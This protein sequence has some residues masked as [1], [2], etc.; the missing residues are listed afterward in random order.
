MGVECGKQNH[1]SEWWKWGLVL[2]RGAFMHCPVKKTIPWLLA[3][4]VAC[5]GQAGILTGP[6]LQDAGSDHMTVMWESDMEGTGW[7]EYV[8]VATSTTG[9]LHL[10]GS[11]HA[12]HSKSRWY[13]GELTG[14]KVDTEYRYRIGMRNVEDAGG[15]FRTFHTNDQA[16]TFIMYAD[17]QS[18]ARG[19][20]L[21]ASHFL[22]YNPRLIICAG[23]LVV[24]DHEDDTPEY[25]RRVFFDPLD[26]VIRHVPLFVS[27]G[28]HD[29]RRSDE[30]F[31]QYFASP[32]NGLNY[33]FSCGIAQF[34]CM[35]SSG[36]RNRGA[37]EREIFEVIQ[38]AFAGPSPGWRFAFQHHPM[39][40]IAHHGGKWGRYTILPELHRHNVDMVMAGHAH[41]YERFLPIVAGA[42]DN[43]RPIQHLVVGPGGGE[44]RGA[45]THELLA[46]SHGY[47]YNFIV[48]TVDGE[49]LDVMAWDARHSNVIDQFSMTQAG[50]VYDD[51]YMAMAVSRRHERG[52]VEAFAGGTA[53]TN[54]PFGKAYEFSPWGSMLGVRPAKP[55]NDAEGTIEFWVYRAFGADWINIASDE[56]ELSR[57]HLFRVKIGE[58]VVD[59]ITN[60]SYGVAYETCVGGVTNRIVAPLPTQG[61]NHIMA[62]YDGDRATASLRVNGGEPVTGPYLETSCRN[63][64]VFGIG[65][66]ANRALGV[67]AYCFGYIDEVRVSTHLRPAVIQSAPFEVDD[68]TVM[69]LRF[70]ERERDIPRD[71]ANPWYG[72]L[73]AAAK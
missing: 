13:V 61:W 2:G 14:L 10:A 39:Y 26:D 40:N 59:G 67:A 33:H 73:D 45:Q 49:R 18:G 8:E 1:G 62:H 35:D 5:V 29:P 15:S 56:P 68:D 23:D 63:A 41:L 46:K 57:Q 34:L 38:D 27:R 65:G 51:A 47:A 9:L 64:A 30:A 3:V 24:A 17:P 55:F 22:R 21:V 31:T 37:R 52:P 20:R 6:F 58:E 19:H 12:I 25:W 53:R 42:Y 28:N 36:P 32:G 54:G 11:H 69:L 72:Q 48:V 44:E 16:F 7:V 43:P 70:E 50:N 71:D 4:L 60:R 66:Q